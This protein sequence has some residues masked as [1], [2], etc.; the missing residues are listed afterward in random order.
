M[1]EK[2]GCGGRGG[3]VAAAASAAAWS[4]V[5]SRNGSK[6]AVSKNRVWRRKDF[7]FASFAQLEADQ[8]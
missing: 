8:R 4:K 6:V 7:L 3:D 1:Q 2:H 5:F